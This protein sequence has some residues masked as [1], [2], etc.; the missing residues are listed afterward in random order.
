MSNN[1][2]MS[3]DDIRHEFSMAMSAMYQAEVPLYGDLIDLVSKVNSEVLAMH[4]DI[5]S[6]LLHTGEI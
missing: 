1:S 2:F 5:K 3:S 4:P 6:Q